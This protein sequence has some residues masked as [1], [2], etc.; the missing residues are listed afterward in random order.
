VI[1]EC[2]GEQARE[3]IAAAKRNDEDKVLSLIERDPTITQ[4]KIAQA[5]KWELFDGK[6]HRTKAARCID[7]LVEDKLVKETRSGRWQLTPEGK[8][9]LEGGEK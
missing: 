2:I 4:A 9:V 8:K 5:M 6:P 3:E 7:R 1:C